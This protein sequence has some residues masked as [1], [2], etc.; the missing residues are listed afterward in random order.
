MLPHPPSPAGAATLA[1]Q[2]GRRAG[3]GLRASAATLA[4]ARALRDASALHPAIRVADAPPDH[5]VYHA[6]AVNVRTRPSH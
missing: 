2:G 4:R 5:G 6:S 3:L 1:R